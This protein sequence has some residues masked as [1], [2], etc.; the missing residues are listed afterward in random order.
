MRNINLLDSETI[1]KIAAGEVVERPASVVKELVENSIDAGAG[2]ITVEIREGGIGMIR[3]TDN[4]SGIDAEDIDT[5]FARHATSKIRSAEDLLTIGS[6]GFRGEALSSIA[7]VSQVELITKTREQPTG[8][9]Y[10]SDGGQT[11]EKTEIG[12]PDGT[13]IIVRNLFFNTPARRK[14]LKSPQTEAGYTSDLVSRLALSHPEISFQYIQNG[15]VRLYTSG[16]GNLKDIVYNVFGRDVTMHLLPVDLQTQDL[17]LTGFIGK[18]ILSRGNRSWENYFI[19]DRYIKSV[20]VTKAIEDAYKTFVMIHKFPFT[21]LHISM[22]QELLDVNVH[23]RKMEL[24]FH[25]NEAIYQQLFTAIRSVLEQRELIPSARLSEKEK[26]QTQSQKGPEPFELQRLATYGQKNSSGS[27]FVRDRQPNYQSRPDTESKRPAAQ[28]R[29]DAVT[30]KPALQVPVDPETKQ[31]AKNDIP[32]DT[33]QAQSPVPAAVQPP[34]QE[35]M[36]PVRGKQMTFFEDDRSDAPKASANIRVIGQIYDTY[37]MFEYDGKLMIMDQHAAHEKVLF[38]R[39][40][41]EWESSKVASQMLAPPVI[42][43]LTPQE[44]GI[45]QKYEEYFKE[46]GFE[47]ESFGGN[48][49]ALYAV[50]LQLFGMSPGD[51]FIEILDYLTEES[52]SLE[53]STITWRIATMACKAAVKGGERLSLSEVK[54]LIEDL[55]KADHPYTCPHGRPTMIH[56]SRYELD[57]KFK[58]IQ[59]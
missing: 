14:F 35:S 11:R 7:A 2:A 20:T 6:L 29:R 38:E 22:D 18:P 41:K 53:G 42:V 46:L 50:P 28:N 43:T 47:S 59:N 4:G 33:K 44:I 5:A 15:Q 51:M 19:N 31:P 9:R 40:R 57:K 23:P 32:A 45:F 25:Q 54:T 37:W 52:K 36:Q 58:R 24:R 3:V 55:F 34:K 21:A 26:P 27:S 13:T 12:C 16:N 30:E 17:K 49:Y 1:N 56:F 8:I 10:L 48:E 39:F